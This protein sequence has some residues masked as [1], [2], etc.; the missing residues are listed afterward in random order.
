MIELKP[1]PINREISNKHK[2]ISP[3]Q[4]YAAYVQNGRRIHIINLK[5]KDILDISQKD[6]AYTFRSR[7]KTIEI[8]ILN[9]KIRVF[10]L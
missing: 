4:H 2:T 9:F 5:D 3:N 8:Y 7:S 1:I 10:Y 6:F